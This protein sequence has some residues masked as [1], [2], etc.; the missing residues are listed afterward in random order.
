M[1]RRKRGRPTGSGIDDSATLEKVAQLVYQNP[2]LK[3]ATAAKQ[4]G[5]FDDSVIRRVREKWKKQKPILLNAAKAKA[6]NVRSSDMSYGTAQRQRFDSNF[7]GLSEALN[8]FRASANPL[9]QVR[10]LGGGATLAEHAKVFLGYDCEMVRISKLVEMEVNSQ[11]KLAQLA[12]PYHLTRDSV[13]AVC[14]VSSL[15][16]LAREIFDLNR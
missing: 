13:E 16:R 10:A 11:K 15:H 2:K 3:F 6:E 5:I 1:S 8:F 7:S 12:D 14:G 4:L 9:D